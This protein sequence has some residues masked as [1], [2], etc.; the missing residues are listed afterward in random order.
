[1]W[2]GL[3]VNCFSVLLD[4]GGFDFWIDELVNAMLAWFVCIVLLLLV[5][6]VLL[7]FC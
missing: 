6:C 7:L 2:F 1:M 5:D 4:C 3:L